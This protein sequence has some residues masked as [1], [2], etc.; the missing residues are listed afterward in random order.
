MMIKYRNF[1]YHFVRGMFEKF[2]CLL[3]RWYAKLKHY[4]NNNNNNN[5]LTLEICKSVMNQK[6]KKK[7][8]NKI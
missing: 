5:F 7:N 4:N 2:A 1:R 8:A 6:K 3:A